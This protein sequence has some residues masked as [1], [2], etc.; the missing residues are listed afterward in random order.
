MFLLPFSNLHLHEATPGVY[1]VVITS[2]GAFL[3]EG[4]M[5]IYGAH[6]GWYEGRELTLKRWPFPSFLARLGR[7]PALMYSYAFG[8]M[9]IWIASGF[10]W[11]LTR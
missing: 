10:L 9:C 6:K 11:A 4:F 8:A 2:A 5:L 1:I 7:W 3:I